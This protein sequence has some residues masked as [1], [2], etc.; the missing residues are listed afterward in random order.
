METVIKKVDEN[1]IDMGIIR[2]MAE[3]IKNGETVIFPTETVYGLGANAMDEDAAKKIY[4]AKGRPSDNP[5]IVHI[6]DIEEVDKIALEVGEKAKKAMEN[7]W[8]GPLTIILKKKEIVPN[9]TSGG[10]ST[11]AIRMPSNKIANAL[12]RESKTQIAAPSANISGR[13]SPTKAEHVV[14]EMSGRVSGIIMGGDCDF[15]LESTV[16]DFSEDKPMILRPGS[17]TKEMLEEVLGEVSIDPSLTKKEDNIKA[18]A[19]GMKYKHYSPNAQVYIV[20]GEENNVIT[21]M[22]ELSRKNHAENKKTGIMCMSKDVDKFECDYVVDLG[23][24]YDEVA[25]N[26]FDALIKMDE[27]KM[28]IVYSVCF[29]SCGVGQAIMNRLLKSAA[30]RIIDAN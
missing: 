17:I 24:D 2:E 10:L 11:V 5:L 26:L 27:A 9:V 12:I 4:V 8:P 25:S 3:K 22:N 30:Y 14:K 29:E 23:K 13:P 28:D 16:V 18:K 21:K 19:P 15:G 20:K 1:N 7:F 6:A